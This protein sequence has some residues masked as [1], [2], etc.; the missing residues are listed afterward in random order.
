MCFELQLYIDMNRKQYHCSTI[1]IHSEKYRNIVTGSRS[2]FRD[3][4]E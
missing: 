2:G 3:V 1:H 4:A